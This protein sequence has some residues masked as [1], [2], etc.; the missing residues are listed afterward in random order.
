MGSIEQ[1]RGVEVGKEMRVVTNY[2]WHRTGAG[3]EG[4]G[5]RGVMK[6]LAGSSDPMWPERDLTEGMQHNEIKTRH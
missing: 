2:L 1:S 5:E 4:F 6:G 3:V